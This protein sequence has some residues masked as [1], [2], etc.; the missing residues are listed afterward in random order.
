MKLLELIKKVFPVHI[1]IIHRGDTYYLVSN[2]T[3]K[4][5]QPSIWGKSKFLRILVRYTPRKRKLFTKVLKF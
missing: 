3:P 4:R 5:G 1:K 2:Q